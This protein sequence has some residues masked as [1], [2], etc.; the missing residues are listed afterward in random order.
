MTFAFWMAFQAAA[1]APA[2]TAPVD[3]DLAQLPRA[4]PD[5]LGRQRCGSSSG[6]TVVVCGRRGPA[7]EYPLEEMER[8]YAEQPV[9]AETG[10]FGNVTADVHGES[11]TLDRGAVSQRVMMRVKI[12]F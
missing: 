1:A 11:A 2:P 5:P 3:F 6:D 7:N 8:R 4:A 9:R 10:L 12:P